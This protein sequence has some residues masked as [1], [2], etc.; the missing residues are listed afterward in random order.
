MILRLHALCTLQVD[1]HRTIQRVVDAGVD[2]HAG[3]LPARVAQ[4]EE[5]R[6]VALGRDR[7]Q[8]ALGSGRLL[9]EEDEVRRLPRE[10]RSVVGDLRPDDALR[11]VDLDQAALRAVTLAR[12]VS[13]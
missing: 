9:V 12:P 5:Q 8:L 6:P 4:L 13:S 11:E 10:D 7:G 2:G 3:D 1:E